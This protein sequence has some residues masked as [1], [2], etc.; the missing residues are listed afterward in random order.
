MTNELN[1]LQSLK[2]MFCSLVKPILKYGS[3]VWDFATAVDSCQLERVQREFLKYVAFILKKN[4]EPHVFT[5]ILEQLCL[6][7]SCRSS[8]ILQH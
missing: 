3:L 7:Y 6:K 4:N 8:S 1:L 2:T 5:P